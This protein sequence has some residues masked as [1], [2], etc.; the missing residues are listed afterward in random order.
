MTADPLSAE[1]RRMLEHDSAI[2][3][4]VITARGYR[5]ITGKKELRV[6]GFSQLQ[7]RVPGLLIPIYPP[8]ATNAGCPFRPDLP[9]IDKQGRVV[10]Y[11]SPSGGGIRIDCPPPCHPQLTDPS[12]PLWI[13]EGI[14]KGDSLASQSLCTLDLIGVWGFKGRNSF[15]GTTVLA[16]LDYVAWNGRIVSIVFDSDVMTKPQVKQALERLTEHLRGRGASVRHIYLPAG[17]N[18]E[19]VGVDDF[20]AAGHSIQELE[21]L[22]REPEDAPEEPLPLVIEQ[23]PDAPVV[24]QARVPGPYLLKPDGLYEVGQAKDRDTREENKEEILVAPAPIIVTARYQDVDTGEHNLEL[25]WRTQGVWQQTT[26]RRDVVADHRKLP[27]SALHGPP[28]TSLNAKRVTA[29]LASYEHI[30]L[31]VCHS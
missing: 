29:Y 15:G 31:V 13:T 27:S 24:H 16:D 25:A 17:P 22:A 26:L 10:K 23:L 5:T 6:L 18:G 12:I 8:G 7:C 30:N 28:I 20:L 19:K 9:R 14:K 4:G 1:H 21:A 3:S 2:T 11:E